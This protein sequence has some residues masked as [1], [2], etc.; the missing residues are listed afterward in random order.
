MAAGLGHTTITATDPVTAIAGSTTLNVTNV[1][2]GG[3]LLTPRAYH[4]A[5]LLSSGQI[6]VTGGWEAYFAGAGLMTA[7]LFDPSTNSSTS[8]VSLDQG[9]FYHTATLLNDGS[10]LIVG[11]QLNNSSADATTQAEIYQPSSGTFAVLGGLN[12]PR[13]Q[14]TATL[15]QD[16]RVLI[17]GGFSQTRGDAVASAEIFD[18]ASGFA[19]TNGNL[20]FAR[21]GHSATLLPDGRVL[22]VGGFSFAMGEL[23][24]AEL[25]DPFADTFS[26][27]GPLSAAAGFGHTATLLPNGTVLIAA[28]IYN[29]GVNP[30]PSNIAEL[31]APGHG[32]G[33]FSQT[34]NLGTA[35]YFH[36]ATLQSNGTVLFTGGQIDGNGT[37]TADAEVYDPASGT[38]AP[39][40]PLYTARDAHTATPLGDGRVVVTGGVVSSVIPVPNQSTL[41][42][43]STVELYPK[44]P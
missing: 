16:G 25:Y 8:T 20:T 7:E 14:H 21:Y 29:A 11:G 22:I 10:V 24:D 44:A 1:V 26:Y 19:Y 30:S 35:R 18:P 4:T 13:Q 17:V 31:Y 3:S 28:G 15:L 41:S 38:F 36:T 40:G 5:T 42:L 34:G 37:P 33:T 2:S 39:A 32:L 9:V 23:N 6:L 27:V 12:I 43:T